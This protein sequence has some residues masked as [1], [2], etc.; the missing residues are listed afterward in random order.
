MGTEADK[1]KDTVGA[2]A[3]AQNLWRPPLDKLQT[4]LPRECCRS[5]H[6]GFFISTIW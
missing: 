6:K 3:S 5:Q 1:H 2:D 4:W